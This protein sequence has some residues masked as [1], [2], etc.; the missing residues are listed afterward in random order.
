V[1]R[2]DLGT[3]LAGREV[4]LTITASDGLA[5]SL[6]LRAQTDADGRFSEPVVLETGGYTLHAVFEG[7]SDHDKFEALR[8]LDL[9]RADVLLRVSVPEGGRLRLDR[10]AHTVAIHAT[11]EEGGAGLEVDLTDELARQL[12]HGTTDANGDVSIVVRGAQLDPPAAGRIIAR[13]ER[14]ARRAEAQTEVPVVRV[15]PTEVTVT[16]TKP[17]VRAGDAVLLSGRLVDH[18]GAGIGRAAVGIYGVGGQAGGGPPLATVLTGRD[19][20]FDAR[21]EMPPDVDD[22]RLAARFESDA[23]WRASS[24]SAPL[25]VHR[26]AADAPAWP[27]LALTCALT[28]LAIAVLARRARRAGAREAD[29][30]PVLRPPGIELA[31]RRGIRPE[32]LDV[33]GVVLD[34]RDEEPVGS[35]RV[36][37]F[38]EG[39]SPVEIETGTDGRFALPRVAAGTWAISIA[40]N[41]YAPMEATLVLPHRG[42]WSS[43]RVRLASL[44]G[45]ALDAVLAVAGEILPARA[46]VAATPREIAARL[47]GRSR[48]ADPASALA[49]DVERA[50]FAEEPPSE[51]LLA[52]AERSRDAALEALRGERERRAPKRPEPPPKGGAIDR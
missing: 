19:G 28:A 20:H 23:P 52:A 29:A 12:G 3:G 36:T 18:H 6:F 14:D 1:L 2:D 42:E 8:E 41:G 27:W 5:D 30:P 16:A 43:L 35:A 9:S 38:R 7:D 15:G 46:A 48:A 4:V 25:V 34:A 37:L 10:A 17:R 50:A 26:A 13:S 32:R 21:V 51:E 33:A 44:R 39:E 22:V 49:R 31:E 47:H 45:R 11:S 40:A 24:E